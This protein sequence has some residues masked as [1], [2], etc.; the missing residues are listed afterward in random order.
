[1]G[2]SVIG[3]IGGEI[4]FSEIYNSSPPIGFL[5][6]IDYFFVSDMKQ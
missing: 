1:M 3:F 2:I 6:N 4:I 5:V